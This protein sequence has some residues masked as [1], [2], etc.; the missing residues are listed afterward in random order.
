[1][2]KADFSIFDGLPAERLQQPRLGQRHPHQVL[3][4]LRGL[5]R[6]VHVH[7]GTLVADVGHLKQIGIEAG[8]C[9]RVAEQR[10]MGSRGAGGHHHPIQIVFSDLLLDPI[11][12]IVGAGVKIVLRVHDVG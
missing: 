7:P 6:L 4:F 10:L 1:M 12:G 5:L 2:T 3:G 8:L 11:L 9:H